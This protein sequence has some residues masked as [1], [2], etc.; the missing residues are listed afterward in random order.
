MAAVGGS[1][2][3]KRRGGRRARVRGHMHL[4]WGGECY[5][6]TFTFL[7]AAPHPAR[8][9][10]REESERERCPHPLFLLWCALPEHLIVYTLHTLIISSRGERQVRQKE[11]SPAAEDGSNVFLCAAP[12]PPYDTPTLMARTADGAL[13]KSGHQGGE[14][15]NPPLHPASADTRARTHRS[16]IPALY[17]CVFAAR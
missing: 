11:S 16:S 10:E 14:R 15:L 8:K 7:T 12:P 5:C 4:G 2:A 9:R 17:V 3:G 13:Y 1:P 6:D